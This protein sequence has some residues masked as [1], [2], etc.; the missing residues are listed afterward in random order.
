MQFS[1]LPQDMM[2][3]S[4]FKYGYISD[5]PKIALVNK[6]LNAFAMDILLANKYDEILLDSIDNSI[7]MHM[8]E[9]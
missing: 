9:R 5:L 6:A 3:N 7:H 8:H 4:I 1:E 2:V